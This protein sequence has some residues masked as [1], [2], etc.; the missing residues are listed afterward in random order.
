MHEP[1]SLTTLAGSALRGAVAGAIATAPMTLAMMA[2]H[3]QLPEHQQYPLPPS[4]ITAKAE[5]VVG[6]RDEVKRDDHVAL[7]TLAHFGYGAAVGALFAPVARVAHLPPVTGGVAYGLTVWTVSYL[8][9][10]PALRLLPPAT[11][12]P[13]ERNSLM[14]AAHVVWGAT[15]GLLLRDK[16]N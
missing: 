3:S 1:V 12:Q 16:H 13:A 2:M 9:L 5:A 6:V 7:T 11:K 4:L 15:L 10:L 8:G 14:I